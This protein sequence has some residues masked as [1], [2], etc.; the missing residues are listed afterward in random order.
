MRINA[1]L[2]KN[3]NKSRKNARFDLLTFV[4]AG[5]GGPKLDA[6][7]EEEKGEQEDEGT[8]NNKGIRT[9]LFVFT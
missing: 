7:G 4:R 5:G 8:E 9:K 6:E 2:T 1:G 3:K